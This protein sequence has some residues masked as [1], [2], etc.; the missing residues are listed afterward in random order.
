MVRQQRPGREGPKLGAYAEQPEQP[1][2]AECQEQSVQQEE[3]IVLASDQKAQK[4]G[5]SQGQQEQ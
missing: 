3:L 2:A 5:T 4:E 1:A